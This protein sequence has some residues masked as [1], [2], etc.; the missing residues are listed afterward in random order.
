MPLIN[1]EVN[2][3][4]TWSRDCVIPNYTGEEKF[5]ITET[6]LYV[7]VVTLSTKDNEK[8]LQQLKSGLKN[9]ISWNKYESSIKTFA[10]NSYLIYLINPSLQGASRLFVLP[11]EN[12]NG[13][14]SHSTCYLPKVEIKDY[15]VMIDGR[16]FFDQPINSMNNTY[17]NI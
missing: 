11:F 6:K 1:C 15:N 12:K 17:E 4:L 2:L 8:L 3:I 14:T 16:N 7:P 10:Q 5:A 9:T 13:R